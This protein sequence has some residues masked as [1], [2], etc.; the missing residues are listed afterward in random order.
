MSSKL[1]IF[2]AE[3]F[4]RFILFILA[5]GPIPNHIA[6]VMDGN[7]RFAGRLGKRPIEGHME[8][9]SALRRVLGISYKL[10][11]R[12]VSVYAFAI[13]N[14]RR[15]PE[16]VN[17]LMDLFEE[18]LHAVCKHGAL[19][20]EYRVRL[21]ILGKTSLF[22][23]R[24]RVAVEKAEQMTKHNKSVVLNVM[25]PYASRD[26]ITTAMQ[27]VGQKVINGDLSLSMITE[28]DI[29]AELFTTKGDNDPVEVLIRTSG[30]RRFS[31][32]LMWQ[33]CEDVQVHFTP[34]YWPDFGLRQFIPIIL[35]Y[36]RK[37]WS[38]KLLI[39][40][41]DPYET[42]VIIQNHLAMAGYVFRFR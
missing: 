21:N 39:P 16:E 8:G 14:F 33:C 3:Q 4:Q 34:V 2:V 5:A 6:F 27:T 11:V 15:S 20:E 10:G 26:E 23:E 1:Y 19:F 31:D 22:P 12:S 28:D 32:F 7:R 37:I 29:N 18:N 42:V 35:D 24:V 30:V 9:F 36:Q 40:Q 38:R 13:D 25:M 41:A 17:G